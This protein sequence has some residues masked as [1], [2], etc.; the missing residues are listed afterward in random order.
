MEK[1]LG[2]VLVITFLGVFVGSYYDAKL[3]HEC[4]MEALKALVD[5]S[6]NNEICG[7]YMFTIFKPQLVQFGDGKFAIRK[8]S[9]LYRDLYLW[10]NQ[11]WFPVPYKHDDEDKALDSYML[12]KYKVV[13]KL[14][15]DWDL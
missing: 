12:T 13:S 8:F 7:W 6:K 15:D 14:D 2:L 1:I 11:E 10:P 9:F 4:R 3:N 5:P